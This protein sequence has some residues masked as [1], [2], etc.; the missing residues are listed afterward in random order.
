M[1]KSNGRK[2]QNKYGE[3]EWTLVTIES[4]ECWSC[5]KVGHTTNHHGIPQHMKPKQN[6]IIPVCDECHK[7]INKCDFRGMLGFLFKINA[8][9]NTM[10]SNVKG[11]MKRKQ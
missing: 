7:E 6:A 1:K 9:V 5:G 11:Y 10:V 2:V 4:S 8:Q 3:K